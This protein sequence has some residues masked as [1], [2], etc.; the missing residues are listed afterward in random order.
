MADPGNAGG[1][2]ITRSAGDRVAM[3]FATGFGSGL[4]PFAPG[5]AGTLVAAGILA[6]LATTDLPPLA[7]TLAL[8]I[9][10]T[11]GCLWIGSRVERVTAG[12]DPQ[13]FVLDEFAGFYVAVALPGNAW[14]SL[15]ELVIAFLLFRLF[16]IIKPWPARRLQ[17]LRGGLGIVIDDLIAGGYAWVGTAV[18]RDLLR[19][20]AG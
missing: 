12:K 10:A 16:D 20:T 3:F 8:A 7:T 2:G 4:S 5:T 17:D 1:D 15:T 19:Q 14:P 13:C 11:L 6:L 9:L 18:A